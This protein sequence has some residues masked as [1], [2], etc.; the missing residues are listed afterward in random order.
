[1]LLRKCCCLM[2]IIMK[3]LLV[4]TALAFLLGTP[5]FAADMPLK[6]AP[7]AEPPCV[8]CGW[9]AG[10]NL[11]YGWGKNTGNGF[12]AFN[13]VD[14]GGI[15]GFFAAGGNVLPG[16]SPKG[17][18]GGGQIG[19]DW[20]VSRAAV[21]G[22][23]ADIQGSGMRA[24]GAGAASIGVFTNITETNNARVDWFGTVR[25]RAGFVAS[26][27]LFYATGGL[28][29]GQVHANTAFIDPSNGNGPVTWAGS[30]STTRA[31]WTAG[32]GLEYAITPK[33][34]FG[35]EYLYVNLGSITVLE[36]QAT[37]FAIPTANTFTST[38]K[39]NSSI[40]RL[41]LNYKF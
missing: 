40:A 9:Y 28:A 31:G 16:V 13:D 20:Q 34:R 29:Y 8:W 4:G 19:Y 25:A 35:A 30:T 39:F 1:M 21:L 11:G 24:S 27:V 41:V 7:Q 6:A 22:L 2:E 12:T 15:A 32:G 10:A 37:R 33:W 5:V 18:V 14:V 17:V 23:V 38:S 36:T 3:K 26:N